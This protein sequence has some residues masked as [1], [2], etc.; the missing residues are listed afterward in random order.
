MVADMLINGLSINEHYTAETVSDIFLVTLMESI[1]I[2][3]C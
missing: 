3:I 2:C 1:P